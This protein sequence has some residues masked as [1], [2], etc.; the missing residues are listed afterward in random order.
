M[1]VLQSDV[2]NSEYITQ[3]LLTDEETKCSIFYK[4]GV[5]I[6]INLGRGRGGCDR[7]VVGFTTT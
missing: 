4:A 7:I 2:H 1:V 5:I 6:Y 3:L